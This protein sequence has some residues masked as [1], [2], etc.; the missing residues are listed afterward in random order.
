T[1]FFSKYETGN[2]AN[3]GI[4]GISRAQRLTTGVKA[5]SGTRHDGAG[6]AARR[7]GPALLTDKKGVGRADSGAIREIADSV[8]G[9]FEINIHAVIARLRRFGDLNRENRDVRCE[10]DVRH[11]HLKQILRG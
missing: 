7:L 11:I 9:A 1:I 8:Q 6:T 4:A 2:G 10:I 3:V 5:G